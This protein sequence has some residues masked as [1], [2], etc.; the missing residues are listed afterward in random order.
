MY[1]CPPILE[2]GS[3]SPID[4]CVLCTYSRLPTFAKDERRT[5]EIINVEKRPIKL[6]ER[7]FVVRAAVS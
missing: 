1:A 3:S 7:I 4:T 6:S 5:T 2:V